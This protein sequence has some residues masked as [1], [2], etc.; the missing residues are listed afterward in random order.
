MND[1]DAH[2]SIM[3]LLT[4]TS[5]QTNMII[6]GVGM[7]HLLDNEKMKIYTAAGDFS[8]FEFE[9]N[10]I[11]SWKGVTLLSIVSMGAWFQSLGTFCTAP[12][13]LLHGPANS[14]IISTST[15]TRIVLLG[16]RK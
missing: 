7:E 11:W 2:C 12:Q 15:I 6:E 9:A 10:A 3:N 4:V 14:R 13:I 5:R 16:G 1:L 8:H